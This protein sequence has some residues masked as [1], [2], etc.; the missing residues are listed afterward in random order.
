MA[1]V[2][3]FSAVAKA[4]SLELAGLVAWVAWLLL[5]LVYLVGFKSKMS[6]VISWRATSL[7]LGRAQLTITKRQT[8]SQR[9]AEE[10]T[11]TE[12]PAK[13]A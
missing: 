13:A 5:R 6:T 2:S 10:P 11:H 8:L 3:R 9:P 1:T 12:L 7:S 4:G